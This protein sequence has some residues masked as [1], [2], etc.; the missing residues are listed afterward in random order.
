MCF[1]FIVCDNKQI[2]L[3]H[4]RTNIANSIHNNWLQDGLYTVD[5]GDKGEMKQPTV[6]CCCLAQDLFAAVR[7]IARLAYLT[8]SSSKCD[9]QPL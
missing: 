7:L 3:K 5:E 8:N 4:I 6:S 2:D 1:K 9:C